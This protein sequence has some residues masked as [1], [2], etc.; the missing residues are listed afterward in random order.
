MIKRCWKH[1]HT[2]G[3]V[4]EAIDILNRY[5]GQ[6]Q[7]IGGGTDLLLE[8]QQGRKPT[9][10][11]MVDPSRI[12]GLGEISRDEEHIVI[13]CAVTH[14]RIISD[15]YIAQH[16]TC[17]VEACGVIGAEREETSST[18]PTLVHLWFLSNSNSFPPRL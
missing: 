15:E 6:A 12:P 10:E 2:P 5:D 11:A 1:Y 4:P 14:S 13:G 16:G 3:S 17:L 18:T 7:V 9:V 8:I